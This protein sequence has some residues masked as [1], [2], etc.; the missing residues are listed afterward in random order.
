MVEVIVM[1]KFLNI[2]NM[3]IPILIIMTL[4]LIIYLL[5]KLIETIKRLNSVLANVD[6][7]LNGVNKSLDKIQEPLDVV[8]KLSRTVSKAHDAT[9][10]AI[11]NLKQHLIQLIELL[12]EK[13]TA[14]KNHKKGE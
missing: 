3:V 9:Y 6:N 12:K 4:L 13:L 8:V 5:I 2:T 10:S 1:D 14:L 11:G 7:T